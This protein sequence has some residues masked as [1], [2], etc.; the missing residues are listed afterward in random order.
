M[1]FSVDSNILVYLVD[2]RD[3]MRQRSAVSII[4]AL[5][6]RDTVLTL[7]SLAEFRHVTIRKSI[8][9]ADV[10]AE[11]YARLRGLFPDPA[12]TSVAT[13]DRALTA[14]TTRRFSFWDAMLLA[15]AAGAGCEALISEDMAPGAELDGVRVFEAFDPA[16]GI[17]PAVRDLLG[18]A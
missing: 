2:A 16:G 13:L 12:P 8:A 14:W 3:R 1:R 6:R 11:Q 9:A 15:A 10:V 4:A 7:Q 5:S 17:A 18:L